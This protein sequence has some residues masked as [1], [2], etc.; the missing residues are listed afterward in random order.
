MKKPILTK[1]TAIISTIFIA[2]IAILNVPQISNAQTTS[3]P[4]AAAL[5][6]ASPTTVEWP[7]APSTSA[8]SAVLIDAD[9]G[10]VLYD[11]N[12]HT[13][14]YPASITKLMTGLLTI[15]NCSLDEIVTF[16]QTAAKSVVPGVDANI[17]TKV[18]EKFTVE[19]SLYALL[20]SSANEVAYGLAEHVAGSLASFTDMMN[21]RAKE[22]GALN[23]HFSNASGLSDTN[24]YTTAYDMAMIGRLCFTNSTFLSIDSYVGN[25]KL[26]PTNLTPEVRSLHS[27]NLMFKGQQYYYQYCK[28]GKT[29]FTDESG[30]TL[31]SYAEKDG[32]R[33][34]CVVMKESKADDRYVDT[35]ALFEYGFNNFKKVSI[36][37]TDVSS[38]FNN[39]NYYS[40]KVYGNT[41]IN[42][43]MDAS[44]VDLPNTATL[45]DVGLTLDNS[46]TATSEET[47]KYDYTAKLNFTYN[48]NTIGSANLLVNTKS[49]IVKSDSLPYLTSDGPATPT[50]KKCVILDVR[51]LA[52]GVG[53]ILFSS[54]IFLNLKHKHHG[55]KRR[56]YAKSKLHY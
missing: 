9:T 53:L 32:M 24:H 30:Y 50:S 25:Y 1:F 13:K 46:K 42:F 39:S 55:K 4:V 21:S 48:G 7:N 19:Q 29:G 26:G 35:K 3:S 27:T 23:T 41:T 34:I 44:Y 11:K 6:T 49:N 16:S 17:A 54:M 12:S 22:L 47:A 31:V 20:L 14:A 28:G 38:L 56:K 33:L 2:S 43:S 52:I 40:S 45:T 37:N 10:A 5:T 8:G 15:E 18:G 36:S 51:Y